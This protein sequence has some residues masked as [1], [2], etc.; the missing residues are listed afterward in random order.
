MGTPWLINRVSTESNPDMHAGY[1]V[2]KAGGG[3][4]LLEQKATISGQDYTRA[5]LLSFAAICGNWATLAC[6]SPDFTRYAKSDRSQWMQVS[7]WPG[8]AQRKLTF[9][10]TVPSDPDLRPVCLRVRNSRC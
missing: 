3:G 10:S 4:P 8:D 5:W 6:N 1:L 2:H 9:H 7:G